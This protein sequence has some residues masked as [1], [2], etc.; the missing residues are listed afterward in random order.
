LFTPAHSPVENSSGTSFQQQEASKVE[1]ELL[2]VGGRLDTLELASKAARASCV[3]RS[4]VARSLFLFMAA[5][6]VKQPLGAKGGVM[7]TTFVEMK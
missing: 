1:E 5:V 4:R 7:C 3:A 6:Q 2:R